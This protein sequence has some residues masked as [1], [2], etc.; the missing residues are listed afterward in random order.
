MRKI[1]KPWVE[2]NL[3]KVWSQKKKRLLQKYEVKKK[4]GCK[5]MKTE[6]WK[7]GEIEVKSEKVNNKKRE[8]LK[9]NSKISFF[10]EIGSIYLFIYFI[11]YICS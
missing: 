1:N 3:A 5:W 10:R 6:F 11:I 4:K 9:L 2:D 7:Y 8:F